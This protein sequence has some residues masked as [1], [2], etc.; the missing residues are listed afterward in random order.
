MAKEYYVY[1]TTTVGYTVEADSEEQAIEDMEYELDTVI[2][3]KVIDRDVWAE[4][5]RDDEIMKKV[6]EKAREEREG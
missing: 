3:E 2:R 6:S 1:E 4:E 5:N